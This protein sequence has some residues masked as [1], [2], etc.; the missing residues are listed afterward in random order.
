MLGRAGGRGD[1]GLPPNAASSPGTDDGDDG[2][3]TG[4]APGGIGSAASGA[5]AGGAAGAPDDGRAAGV[6]PA[7]NAIHAKRR[8]APA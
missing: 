5:G 1:A 2:D 4:A 7:Q 6:Q 3:D 8:I